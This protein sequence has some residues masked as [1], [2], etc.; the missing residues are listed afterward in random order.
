MKFYPQ[1]NLDGLFNGC[2]I[3]SNNL[4]HFLLVYESLDFMV[5][6]KGQRRAINLDRRAKSRSQ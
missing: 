1:F 3:F 2:A 6:L 5:A 4:S